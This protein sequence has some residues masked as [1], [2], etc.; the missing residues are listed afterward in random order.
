MT[1]LLCMP[2]RLFLSFNIL[3]RFRVPT[4]KRKKQLAKYT[5]E[6]VGTVSQG[7]SCCLSRIF[8]RQPQRASRKSRP[9]RLEAQGGDHCCYCNFLTQRAGNGNKI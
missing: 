9:Q 1:K 3:S 8:S 6:V 4:E 7:F 2:S 5:R